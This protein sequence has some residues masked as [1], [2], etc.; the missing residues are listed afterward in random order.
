MESLGTEDVREQ[1]F[2]FC[3]D[4]NDKHDDFIA[5]EI[6]VPSVSQPFLLFVADIRHVVLVVRENPTQNT[7]IMGMIRMP[8]FYYRGG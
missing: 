7:S 4:A 1:N 3:V 6:I 2:G 8:T 5:F